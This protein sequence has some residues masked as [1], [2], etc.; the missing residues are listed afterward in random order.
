MLYRQ[1]AVTGHN[2][3]LGSQKISDAP[4]RYTIPGFIPPKKACGSVTFGVPTRKVQRT[5]V[6]S[7]SVAGST[8]GSASGLDDVV[9]ET[10][11]SSPFSSTLGGGRLGSHRGS[12]T[13]K[14]AGSAP[15]LQKVADPATQ[16]LSL[17]DS[18]LIAP[19]LTTEDPD[20]SSPLE[21]RVLGKRRRGSPTAKVA[22]SAPHLQKVAEPAT[23]S[24]SL[25][26]SVRSALPLVGVT[27]PNE[28]IGE[29]SHNHSLAHLFILTDKLSSLFTGMVPPN[30][31][32][33]TTTIPARTAVHF[34]QTEI[35]GLKWME[36]CDFKGRKFKLPQAIAWLLLQYG[37]SGLID[38]SGEFILD[39]EINHCLRRDILHSVGDSISSKAKWMG[40]LVSSI[41]TRTLILT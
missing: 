20:T 33:V 23:Q 37:Q 7:S 15:H 5:V 34:L 13:A 21:G 1:G 19:S 18:V 16:S 28:D 32:L 9:F 10:N 3:P 6:G 8:Q 41:L 31:S 14:V 12:P 39:V 25:R 40:V 24:L 2:I 22:G 38:E 29:D 27:V 26:G 35:I 17:R 36:T 30:R 4:R 11:H